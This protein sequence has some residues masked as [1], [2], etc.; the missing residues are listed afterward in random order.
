[1]KEEGMTTTRRQNVAT[2]RKK[3]KNCVRTQNGSS[4]ER[5]NQNR[6]LQGH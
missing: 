1:M 6:E 3:G 2:R 5:P 4:L